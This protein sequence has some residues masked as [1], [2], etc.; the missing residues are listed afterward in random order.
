[1]QKGDKQLPPWGPLLL[2]GDAPIKEIDEWIFPAP[3]TVVE[4][5]DPTPS[6]RIAKATP[7]DPTIR[8]RVIATADAAR[9][10][11]P[12]PTAVFWRI[13][14]AV[15]APATKA[16]EKMAEK[17]QLRPQQH[18]R[19]QLER[20]HLRPK[21]HQGVQL[22]SVN[23][24]LDQ[25]QWYKLERLHHR[26]QQHPRIQLRRGHLR[27]QQHQAKQLDRVEFR[28]QQHQ[29]VQLERMH[30][31]LEEYWTVPVETTLSPPK[32]HQIIHLKSMDLRPE[33]DQEVQPEQIHLVHLRDVKRQ[34][35]RKVWLH[36]EP[37][38]KCSQRETRSRFRSGD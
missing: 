6:I 23:H 19:V 17:V 2:P 31:Q 3:W 38:S 24:Q 12:P 22:M 18:Q 20:V 33:V 26:P 15:T 7:K 25:H 28:L 13:N 10:G 21:Q 5:S 35:S 8:S 37:R 9:A 34:S 36:H 11:V 29:A 32:R 4:G 16:C 14:R 30:P 1:M 27:P